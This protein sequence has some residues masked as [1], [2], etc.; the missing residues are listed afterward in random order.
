MT[1][2]TQTFPELAFC[3]HEKTLAKNDEHLRRL[4]LFVS[5][6]RQRAVGRREWA[7]LV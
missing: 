7:L 4:S 2:S 5:H 1:L 6:L 3:L